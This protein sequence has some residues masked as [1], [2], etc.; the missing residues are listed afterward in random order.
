MRYAGE[1]CAPS[2]F[3]D[4]LKSEYELKDDNENWQSIRIDHEVYSVR[5]LSEIRAEF[6]RK[7]GLKLSKAYGEGKTAT[8]LTV[9]KDVEAGGDID[10]RVDIAQHYHAS[11]DNP[12]LL[13][14]TRD[15]WVKELC[16]QVTQFL[17]TGHMMVVVNHG[18][19][20]DQDGFW[21]YLWR[22]GLEQLIPSG[23]F[24]VH[25]IDVSG[26]AVDIH[27]LAPAAHVEADL[28]TAL[29]AIER[30]HAVDDLSAMIM[31][32]VPN[33]GAAEARSFASGLVLSHVDDIQRLHRKYGACIMDLSQ[34][35]A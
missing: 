21:R 9:L 24:L 3:L 33:I 2:A 19:R 14:E 11:G 28:P 8:S 34:R 27:D 13:S 4:V 15:R 16:D 10:A 29:S 17:T 35:Y 22:D 7:I 30:D 6:V 20:E 5:Y 1:R 25:M 23:L 12:A 31:R 18:S 32:E 26:P